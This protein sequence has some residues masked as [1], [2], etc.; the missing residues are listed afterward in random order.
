MNYQ[1][2]IVQM[3]HVGMEHNVLKTQEDIGMINF[4]EQEELKTQHGVIVL[5]LIKHQ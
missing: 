1:L 5:E 4:M 3:I 2:L